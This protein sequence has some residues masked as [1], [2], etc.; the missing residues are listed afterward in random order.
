MR[1]I[2]VSLVSVILV[3]SCS[4]TNQVLRTPQVRVLVSAGCVRTIT[5]DQDVSN[6]SSVPRQ[7]LLPSATPTAALICYYGSRRPGVLNGEQQLDS[8][9]ATTL[10]KV[11]NR[12]DLKVSSGV[13]HCPMAN[14]RTNIF[15]FA[16]QTGGD[17]DLWMDASGCEG[18]DNGYVAGG[19][20][21]NPSFFVGFMGAMQRLHDSGPKAMG[22]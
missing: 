2:A 17:V 9:Q 21:A 8:V 12:I 3:C 10:A 16:Y 14:G 19:E 4:S 11:I 13:A 15:A 1:R 20:T 22:R 7:H 18:L 6:S 5:R